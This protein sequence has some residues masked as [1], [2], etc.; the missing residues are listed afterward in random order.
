MSAESIHKPDGRFSHS[1]FIGKFFSSVYLRPELLEAADKVHTKAMKNGF[2]GH[3][4]AL[5]W[6]LHHSAL[7]KDL[8]DGMIVGASSI[9]H[10]EENLKACDGGPLPDDVVKVFEEIW[11]LAEPVAPFAYIETLPE[12]AMEGLKSVQ[13]GK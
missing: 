12:D 5:R 11:P 2:N 13:N 6:C 8:G 1:S 9:Q 7:K 10:L 3:E 4:A